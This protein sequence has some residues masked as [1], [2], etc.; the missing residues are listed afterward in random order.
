MKNPF[1]IDALL[2]AAIAG[3]FVLVAINMMNTS[4]ENQSP[5]TTQE[6]FLWGAGVG[7]GVQI[8]VRVTGVS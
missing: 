6:A 2:V 7:L 8:V 1:D 5:L 3:A 4:S